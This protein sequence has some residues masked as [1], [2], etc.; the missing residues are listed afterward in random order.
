M[1]GGLVAALLL[2]GCGNDAPT[3]QE[4]PGESTLPATAASGEC[5]VLV[6]QKQAAPDEAFD[7]AH[8]MAEGGA[9]SCATGTSASEFEAALAA[10]REAAASG[11]KARLLGQ[12]GIP[13]LYIDRDGNRRELQEPAKLEAVFDE[14]FTPETIGLLGRVRL[15]DLT[16]V[17]GQGAFVELGSVWLVVDE[18]GGR[19][20]IATVNQQALGEAAVAARR[21]A[22]EGQTRPA[23]M[24][25][26]T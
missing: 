5:L 21:A 19:P 9:I 7:R 8:D 18:P 2:A 12:L 16:V 24:K 15:E 1:A 3:E 6:W 17:A 22:R 20:R 4:E 26:G 13:L 11:D 10:I 14:V 25:S 23:P